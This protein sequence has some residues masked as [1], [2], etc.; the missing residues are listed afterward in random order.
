MYIEKKIINAF[1][2]LIH[3][4]NSCQFLHTRSMITGVSCFE[5]R[6]QAPHMPVALQA[7]Q[8]TGCYV[9]VNQLFMLLYHGPPIISEPECHNL[10]TTLVTAAW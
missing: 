1:V 9:Q 8:V 6:I 5:L 10:R 3:S 2:R 7:K 4:H